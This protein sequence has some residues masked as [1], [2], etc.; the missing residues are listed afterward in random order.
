M[1]YKLAVA[2][3]VEKQLKRLPADW[4]TRIRKQ[5]LLL[6]DDPRPPGSKKIQGAHSIYRIRIGNY[7]VIYDVSDRELTVLI[8]KVGHRREIYRGKIR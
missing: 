2:A 3:K 5:I 6:A 4:A 1:R 8:V 7:R